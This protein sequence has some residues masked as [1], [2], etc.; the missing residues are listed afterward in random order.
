M[1]R[2]RYTSSRFRKVMLGNDSERG[3]LLRQGSILTVTSY[4]NRTSPVIR[5]KW[6]LDNILGVPPPPPPPFVPALKE[7]GGI[8]K[9][10]S[11]RERLAQHRE[12]PACSGCHQLMDPVGF[13]FE[14]Y[15]GVGR[16]RNL[17]DSAVIDAAGSLP[18]GSKFQ[19]VKGLQQTLLQRPDGFLTTFTEKLLTYSIGRGVEGYDSPAVRHILHE[20]RTKDYQFSSFILGIVNSPPFQMRRSQ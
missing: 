19:G 7:N 17:D 11:M 13:A 12:N 10:L 5:G 9:T 2:S 8:G 16:W 20:A 3:G 14:N 15:D 4:P 1:W 6:I 18:D